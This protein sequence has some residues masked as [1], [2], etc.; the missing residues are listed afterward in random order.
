M[1][2]EIT[3][4]YHDHWG[5]GDEYGPSQREFFNRQVTGRYREINGTLQVQLWIGTT[6]F[7]RR[8]KYKWFSHDEIYFKT[9]VV[10]YFDCN[11]NKKGYD[12][13]DLHLQ[14]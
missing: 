13:S 10:E 11:K 9:T 8:P 6:F 4:M 14:G 1:Q 7:R 12:F 5:W 2:K 3:R